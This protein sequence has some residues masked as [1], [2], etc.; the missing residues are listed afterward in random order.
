MGVVEIIYESKKEE[1]YIICILSWM[2][3]RRKWSCYSSEKRENSIG[4]GV[5]FWVNNFV[6]GYEKVY[7]CFFWKFG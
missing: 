7:L 2:Y 5:W 4:L 6:G 3:K 1:K